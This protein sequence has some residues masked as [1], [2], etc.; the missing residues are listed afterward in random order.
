MG[1]RT[2]AGKGLVFCKYN[3]QKLEANQIGS[4]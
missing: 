4:Q 1:R 3:E 2:K